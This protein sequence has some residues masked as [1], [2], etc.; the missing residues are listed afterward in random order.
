[1]RL[2]AWADRISAVLLAAALRGCNRWRDPK[3]RSIQ[4]WSAGGDAPLAECEMNR[5][6]LI[7]WEFYAFMALSAWLVYTQFIKPWLERGRESGEAEKPVEH[8][9]DP[10]GPGSP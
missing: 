2:D 4:T 8:S 1:M 6:W 9:D 10:A 5:E 3:P 7:A